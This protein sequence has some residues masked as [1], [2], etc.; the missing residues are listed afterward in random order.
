MKLKAVFPM[1][2][3]TSSLER[4]P[5]LVRKLHRFSLGGASTPTGKLFTLLLHCCV[6]RV[7]C[8]SDVWMCPG[9]KKE[10]GFLDSKSFI[11]FVDAGHPSSGGMKQGFFHVYN[12]DL[13]PRHG[14]LG[15]AI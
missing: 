8:K 14:N 2:N 4:L 15:H 5:L 13:N 7:L 9:P 11:F 10:K 12:L 3:G 6:D 1:S